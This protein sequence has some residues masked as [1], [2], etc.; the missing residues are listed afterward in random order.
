MKRLF[1][2]LS[3]CL[4]LIPVA[5]GGFT[6]TFGATFHLKPERNSVPKEFRKPIPNPPIVQPQPMI[7]RGQSYVGEFERQ[8]I[9]Q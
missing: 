1:L 9:K 5:G 8:F 3:I 7:Q 6:P 4:L 2:A